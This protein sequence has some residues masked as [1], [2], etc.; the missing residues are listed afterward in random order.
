[1]RFQLDGFGAEAPCE[2]RLGNAGIIFLTELLESVF[3]D[4]FNEFLNIGRLF[5]TRSIS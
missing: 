4:S 3:I 2:R 5:I 1:M